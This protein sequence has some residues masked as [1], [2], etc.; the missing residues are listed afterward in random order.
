MDN[1][2]CKAV[3]RDVVLYIT[4]QD[5]RDVLLNGPAAVAEHPYIDAQLSEWVPGSD[6]PFDVGE[7]PEMLNYL[8]DKIF[9]T[10]PSLREWSSEDVYM[11]CP[12][13]WMTYGE[14]PEALA[15]EAHEEGYDEDDEMRYMVFK[16]DVSEEY[17]FITSENI[18][19]SEGRPW[20]GIAGMTNTSAT[21]FIDLQNDVWL[22]ANIG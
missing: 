2:L 19:R 1:K 10:P 17:T 5:L 7:T 18:M 6:W 22:V 13:E 16:G 15:R 3:Y 14:L 4:E 21:G 20:H 8:C 11:I 9:L 12:G